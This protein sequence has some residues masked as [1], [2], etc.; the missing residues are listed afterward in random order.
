DEFKGVKKP[1]DFTGKVVLTT[2]SSSGI[3]EAV[4]KLFSL[5]GASVVVT[6]RK[7]QEVSRVAKEA[8]DLSPQKLK[9]LEVVADVGKSDDLKRL[10]DETIK[11]YGKLDVLVNNA[12]FGQYAGIR[13]PKLMQVFDTTIAVNLRAYLELIQL[14]VPYLD[15]TNGTI[16]S[17]SSIAALTPSMIGM[18][19]DV[20]KAA[21]DM[22]SKS[23]ALELGPKIRINV[24]NPGVTFTN[25]YHE[26]PSINADT[27][28]RFIASTPLKRVGHPLDMARAV[29]F[30][31][32]SDAN[33]ITGANLVI[34]GGVVHN[35]PAKT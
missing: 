26:N 5:L 22:M 23:L 10:L 11:A 17:M 24:I 29:V 21:I 33:F 1:Y 15:Q 7:G 30:L 14:S 2:G 31:A 32:S 20:S 25:F 4:V 19:Y 18:S 12:G 34:D 28:S 16:I 9:L 27:V 35:M 6:G 13:D 8:Q 3:G